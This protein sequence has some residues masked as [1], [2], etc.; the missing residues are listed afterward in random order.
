MQG[1]IGVPDG[2]PSGPEQISVVVDTST[3]PFEDSESMSGLS[4]SRET[5]EMEMDDTVWPF[6]TVISTRRPVFVEDLKDR[7][8]G[9]EPRGLLDIP[10]SGLVLPIYSSQDESV[11]SLILVAGLN[12]AV[13][14][15]YCPKYRL[16]TVHLARRPWNEAYASFV[17]LLTQQIAAG[18]MS[19]LNAERDKRKVEELA[20]LNKA[21]TTFS[22]NVN[23]ELRTVSS[24]VSLCMVAAL[25]E[26]RS[27]SN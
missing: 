27:R 1:A 4:S 15:L 5:A 18:V 21:R 13:L 23:H 22:Q 2:H 12:C 24:H 16:M 25:T 26:F 10:T 17:H 19:V 8:F 11:P 20:A 7:A 3:T 6:K 9:F 14:S